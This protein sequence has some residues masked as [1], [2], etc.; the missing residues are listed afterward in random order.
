MPS[1]PRRITGIV[2]TILLGLF[3]IGAS[4]IPKF[5]DWP[6]K[7]EMNQ[8]LGIPDSLLAPIGVVEIAATLL[9]FGAQVISEYERLGRD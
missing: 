5:V 2:L 1:K 8:K 6:G 4:G 7:S 3:L 9:L